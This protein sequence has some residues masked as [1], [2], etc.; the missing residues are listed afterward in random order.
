MSIKLHY[1]TVSPLLKSTLRMLMDA[2]EFDSF[3][4]VGGTALSL[5]R[6]HR[7]SVDIDLFT[8]ALYGS[9]N[10]D[11]LENFLREKF[12]HID[13]G[14]NNIVGMGKSYFA[15]HAENELLKIDLYYS[16]DPFIFPPVLSKGVRLA[17]VAEIIAMK[18]DVIQRGG[19]KK[20]FWDIHELH[21]EYSFTGMLELHQQRYPY[22]HNRDLLIEKFTDFSAADNDFEPDC[23]RGK[24]W[25][26]I[27]LDLTDFKNTAR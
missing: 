22:S 19:R 24:Y 23:L 4:L 8:D 12:T 10:F 1:N 17:S 6:G 2:P 26:L 16:T 5:L 13:P 25:E 18:M 3:R 15:G 27:K 14:G 7:M 11:V 9:V 21:E 20:D